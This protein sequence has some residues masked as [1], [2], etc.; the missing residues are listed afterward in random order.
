MRL[1]RRHTANIQRS[2]RRD[3]LQAPHLTCR[4]ISTAGHIRKSD[5]STSNHFF[6]SHKDPQEEEDDV[7]SFTEPSVLDGNRSTSVDAA[8]TY[9]FTQILSVTGGQ[10]SFL[11]TIQV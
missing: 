6:Y 2:Q 9:V 7:V 10:Y 1:R 8:M 11:I 4:Q 3:E 5:C